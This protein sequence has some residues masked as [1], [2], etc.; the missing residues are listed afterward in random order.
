MYFTE[1]LN[2]GRNPSTV[3]TYRDRLSWFERWLVDRDLQ[4][5]HVTPAVMHE[6]MTDMRSGTATGKVHSAKSIHENVSAV[7][8]FFAW[9]EETGRIR[10]SPIAGLK[11]V[12]VP[13]KLPKVL[14]LSLV[15][16]VLRGIASTRDQVVVELL[17]GS[18]LRNSELRAVRLEDVDLDSL[19]VLIRGKG[20][21][22]RRQPITPEAAGAI[23]AWLPDR[24]ALLLEEG[25]P[26]DGALVVGRFGRLRSAQSLRD[27]LKAIAARAGISASVYPHL[28]RHCFA[29]HFLERGGVNLRQLQ[30]L[31]GHAKLAT[32]EIY[33]HVA[34][35]PLHEAFQRGH[36]RSVVEDPLTPSRRS[37]DDPAPCGSPGSSSASA[38][39]TSLTAHTT[40]STSTWTLLPGGRRP[41]TSPSPRPSSSTEP[42]PGTGH[43]P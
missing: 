39:L 13:K 21:K 14:P 1:L 38:S 36:P 23:R 19:A 29:T 15:H 27:I 11:S 33:T 20:G 37:S 26:D 24:A 41:S 42:G 17:Y 35:G 30:E 28:L 12:K 5:R 10:R 9:L 16:Q 2:Y 22:E 40:P 6:W 4:L 8:R 25:A 31:L 3:K 32:T 7:K 43:G 34:Q 18:G